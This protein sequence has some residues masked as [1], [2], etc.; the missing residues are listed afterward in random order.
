[1]VGQHF[2]HAS[3]YAHFRLRY[4][5]DP[6]GSNATFGGLYLGENSSQFSIVDWSHCCINRSGELPQRAGIT[7]G[8]D[9]NGRAS[10][11]EEAGVDKTASAVWPQ[12]P[13]VES[14][15]Q[16]LERRRQRQGERTVCTSGRQGKKG[17]QGKETAGVVPLLSTNLLHEL[18]SRSRPLTRIHLVGL[19]RSLVSLV[20]NLVQVSV[21]KFAAVGEKEPAREIVPRLSAIQ[22]QLNRP[23][24]FFIVDV[25]QNVDSLDNSAI[26][27]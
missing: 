5:S 16:S 3:W 9:V 13:D 10:A 21:P 11:R 12:P 20:H 19:R 23:P 15:P 8:K 17:M 27:R 7:S 2:G 26:R 14:E 1:V 22:L 24:K 25:A 4:E 6:S 18:S